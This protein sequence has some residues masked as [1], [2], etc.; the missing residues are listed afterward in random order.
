LAQGGPFAPDLLTL[1]DQLGAELVAGSFEDVSLNEAGRLEACLGP[2]AQALVVDDPEAT[3][4]ALD[5]RSDTL[6]N[7]LLVS[8]DAD[9][10]QLA[11]ATIRIDV[12]ERDV[13]IQD[14]VALRV[15]RIP[16]HPRLGRRAREARAAELAR[17]VEDVRA[18]RRQLE[19][20]VAD[21]EMLLAGHAIWLAGDPAPELA[22]L[23]R[24][25]V[26]AEAKLGIE[27]AAGVR[28][29]ETAREIR[30]RVNG[31]RA[32]LSE[33]PLLD[34]PDFAERAQAL[35]HDLHAARAAKGAVVRHKSNAEFVDRHQTVLRQLPLTEE[36]I[37]RIGERVQL[38]TQ[39][40]ERLK[41]GIEALEYVQANV[42][43][44]SW[45]DAPARLENEQALVPALKQQIQ[46]AD[47][48]RALSDSAAK[49]AEGRFCRRVP[50]SA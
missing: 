12:G 43:A 1:R 10:E 29:A 28:H 6:A 33:A 13:A 50:P 45:E 42:E 32:L 40:R 21:G 37:V 44:L 22:E 27:R 20:L 4:R 9:L 26:E 3:A 7:V 47:Q 24:S 8:R 38:L 31:L 2:L 41:E 23:K 25:V 18:R 30:P 17:E 5:A 34:P 35:E 15:S 46:E 19:R 14:G 49:N 48:H 11:S 39:R 16:S 36:D